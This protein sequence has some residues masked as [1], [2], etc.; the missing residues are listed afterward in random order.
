MAGSRGLVAVAV[1]SEH[2]IVHPSATGPRAWDSYCS[3]ASRSAAPPRRG[4]STPPSAAPGPSGS[5]VCRRGRSG[6]RRDGCRRWCRSPFLTPS[7]SPWPSP[8]A[9][10]QASSEHVDGHELAALSLISPAENMTAHAAWPPRSLGPRLQPQAR[11]DCHR[12][13]PPACS[14]RICVAYW[15]SWACT[16]RAS[17]KTRSRLLAGMTTAPAASAYT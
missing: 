13:D 8:G 3:A 7:T 14:L 4:T 6:H 2:V 1:G 11:L 16:V 5:R 17:F 12:C 10:P 9:G 15:A